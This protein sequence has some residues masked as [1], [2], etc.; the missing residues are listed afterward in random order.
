MVPGESVTVDTGDNQ[1]TVEIVS[2][3]ETP[4]S[5][6]AVF[7]KYHLLQGIPVVG[8]PLLEPQWGQGQNNFVADIN[9]VALLIT[10]RLRMFQGEWW[11]N[12]LDGLPLWQQILA[13]SQN[14]EVINTLI[15][16]RILNTPYV[17]GPVTNL[18][19]SFNPQTRQFLYSA[20]VQTQFGQVQVSNVPTP[21]SQ[22]LP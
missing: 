6:S 16:Q 9:A 19:A 20:T 3:T 21:P 15:T 18:E 4:P 1:E 8:L 17:T 2:V 12:Q 5:F 22:A 11:V 7:S 10:T 13:K 14:T